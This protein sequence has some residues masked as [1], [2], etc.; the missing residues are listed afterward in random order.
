MTINVERSDL[1]T[2]NS[3][4][5]FTNAISSLLLKNYYPKISYL[6]NFNRYN[7]WSDGSARWAVVP[8]KIKRSLCSN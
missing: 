3:I 6:D 2:R 1:E 4:S 8:K 5:I 7:H